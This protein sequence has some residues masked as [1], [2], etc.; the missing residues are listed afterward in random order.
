MAEINQIDLLKKLALSTARGVPQL[1]TGFVDLAS[2]PFTLSGLLEDEDVF[3]STAYL[4]KKGLL[5]PPQE[6]IL[7]QSAELATSMVNPASLAKMAILGGVGSMKMVGKSIKQM[8]D[9]GEVDFVRETVGKKI[10]PKEFDFQQFKDSSIVTHPL[11]RSSR[12]QIVTEISGQ[13]INKELQNILD[14]GIGFAE[15]VALAD[16]NI[17]MASKKNSAMRQFNRAKLIAEENLKMG[18]SGRVITAPSIM[19]PSG[20][21]FSTMPTEAIN[22]YIKSRGFSAKELSVIDAMIRA[23]SVKGKN[24]F[25]DFVGLGDSKAL[26]QMKYGEGF[27]GNV[28]DLRKTV[29]EK[30]NSVKAQKIL[31]LNPDDLR[32]SLTD[33]RFGD[34]ALDHQIGSML[35]ELDLN[36]AP[37]PSI[38]GS[39][40]ATYDY[41]MFGKN[42]G[43]IPPTQPEGLFGDIYKQID[44]YGVPKIDKSGKAISEVSRKHNIVNTLRDQTKGSSLYLDQKQIDRLNKIYNR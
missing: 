11:D 33:A 2:L 31:G 28:S 25:K 14:G 1:A 40:H 36:K 44:N 39:K 41:D 7:N 18:G 9:E 23:K 4:T 15:D 13:P 16:K 5:P 8:L 19:T 32:L 21:D 38:L 37:M 30:V 35:Y 29:L 6:G 22:A 3:G 42:V 26:D 12:N 43:S 10:K 17:V 24:P 20:I 27:S 34:D